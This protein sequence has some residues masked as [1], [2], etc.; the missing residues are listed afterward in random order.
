MVLLSLLKVLSRGTLTNVFELLSSNS[1]TSL[2]EKLENHGYDIDSIR[3]SSGNET[4]L[5]A[6]QN[7]DGKI[8]FSLGS[9]SLTIKDSEQQ[10]MPNLYEII[11]TDSETPLIER[12]GNEGYDVDTIEFTADDS[13]VTSISSSGIH[14]KTPYEYLGNS[15]YLAFDL[16]VNLTDVA[17]LEGTIN[18][19]SVGDVN[20]VELEA[21]NYNLAYENILKDEIELYFSNSEWRIVA[22]DIE[23]SLEGS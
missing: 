21:V 6:T 7:S 10:E 11:T 18:K 5:S 22:S 20:K 15:R 14:F 9:Q 8:D 17:N 23:V 3:L 16:D 19:L 4:I 13:S 12:L 2:S 1:G